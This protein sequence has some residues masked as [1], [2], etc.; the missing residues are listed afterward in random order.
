MLLEE[1][2]NFVW[3][4]FDATG[5]D[6]VSR[7]VM[8][9]CCFVSTV[10]LLIVETKALL[11]FRLSFW[12][13][14]TARQSNLW[15]SRQT[16]LKLIFVIWTCTNCRSRPQGNQDSGR[17]NGRVH[18]LLASVLPAGAGQAVNRSLFRLDLLQPQDVRRFFQVTIKGPAVLVAL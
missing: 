5:P 8:A 17:D 11:F 4:C 14:S 7:L 13:V 9:W 3:H 1:T 6:D 18:R 16:D 12:F 15:F 10:L 2:S